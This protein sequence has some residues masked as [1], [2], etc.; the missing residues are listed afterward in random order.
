MGNLPQTQNNN[1]KPRMVKN[2]KRALLC[3]SAVPCLGAAASSAEIHLLTDSDS[4][5]YTETLA[6]QMSVLFFSAVLKQ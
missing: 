5:R 4:P 2:V 6:W 3:F 1:K